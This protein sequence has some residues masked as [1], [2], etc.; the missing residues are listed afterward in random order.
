MKNKIS[1]EDYFR[2]MSRFFKCFP[3]MIMYTNNTM[4]IFV[5]HKKSFNINYSN[6]RYYINYFYNKKLKYFSDKSK[7]Y[8]TIDFPSSYEELCIIKDLKGN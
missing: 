4:I 5:D 7:T 8:A 1:E 2:E 6:V 3:I